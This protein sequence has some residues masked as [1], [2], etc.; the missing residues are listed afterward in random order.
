M[1]TI[2]VS[3]E[4]NKY[5]EVDDEDYEKLKNRKWCRAKT[6]FSG[7]INNKSVILTRYILNV[8]KGDKVFNKDGNI[9]NCKKD[10]LI[11]RK[12][13]VIE[14]TKRLTVFRFFNGIVGI[15]NACFYEEVKDFN[16]YIK[17][18]KNFL[19]IVRDEH[20]KILYLHRLL[21]NAPDDL[22][23]DHKNRNTL[24]NRIKNLRICTLQQNSFNCGKWQARKTSSIYKGVKFHN[25]AW[26]A[27]INFNRKRIYLGSYKTQEEAALA[28]NAK[29]VELFG[30]YA[31]PNEIPELSQQN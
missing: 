12:K 14:K 17:K 2:K 18:R 22:Y 31:C 4:I 30:E 11:I 21:K 15:T 8:C 20:R 7:T 25:K 24:D 1:K 13:V 9:Y 28:Y 19:Y 16:W 5:I 10:N 6:R 23:V 29:C 26:E 27:N 3:N